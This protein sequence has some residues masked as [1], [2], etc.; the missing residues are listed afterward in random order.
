MSLQNKVER[1]IEILGFGKEERDEYISKSLDSSDEKRE[2]ELYFKQHPMLDSLVYIP[3]HL[4]IATP[5]LISA[6]KFTQNTNG[7]E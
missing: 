6:K 1:R 5:I 7:N 4:S 2:L 3:F